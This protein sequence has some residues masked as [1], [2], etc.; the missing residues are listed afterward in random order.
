MAT[1]AIDS[2]S[3]LQFIKGIGPARSKVLAESGLKTVLDLLYYFPRR[4]LN[5]TTVTSIKELKR[6]TNVTVIGSVEVCGERKTRKGKLYQAVL[7]DGTGLINLLWFNGISYVKRSLKIGDRLAVH[8]KIDF[9]KGYQIIHPEYDKLDAVDDPVATGSI[10]PLYPLS[11]D[12]KKVGLD[13]RRL[14]KTIRDVHNQTEKIQ[15]FLP[16]EL[17]KKYQLTDLDSAL[18][19][20]HFA[21]NEDQL[22]KSVYRLKFEEHLFLQILMALRKKTINGLP[23]RILKSTDQLILKIYKHIPYKLT[24]SQNMVLEEI[25]A[26]LAK[27][28]V[29][30]RLLQGDVGSGKTIIGIIAALIAVNNNVQVAVMAPTEILAK[31]HFNVFN[32]FAERTQI[33]CSLLVGKLKPKERESILSALKDGRIN[34]IVGTHALIQSDVEF[35]DLGFVIVDEQHRFGVVQRGNLLAKGNNPHFL[36]MTATPIPRTLAITF[37]GDMDL[38]IIDE[39]PQ[40][41]IPITT[42]VVEPSRLKNI[43][44]FISEE[45]QRGQQCIIVYPL[46]EES[47]KSDLAAA[48]EAHQ[49]LQA[50]IFPQLHVGIIHGRMKKEEKDEVMG[51]FTRNEIQIL[52]ST[53]VIEVGIDIP[54]ATVMLIEHADRFGLTQLHQLRGRVGRGINKS[55]CILVQRNVN[56]TSKARLDI[57]E[58]ISDG[59]EISDEDLKIRGPGEY[60]GIRQSGFLSYRIA[61]LVTDGPIIRSARTAAFDLIKSDP[62]LRRP[63]H[64]DIRSRFIQCYQ[65][66][67]EFVNIN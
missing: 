37:H 21:D 25:L 5:R 26:D 32:K 65:D 39:M 56:E 46:V 57:I 20:I 50:E 63:L 3:A 4:H 60:F 15:D 24:N 44:K 33:T 7:N 36:A 47:E 62:H 16:E 14:R 58:R 27:P 55:F 2:D 52:V 22:A 12:F 49:L 13:N 23:A 30:N 10:I 11:Q 6:G 34:I 19:W 9:Y 17:K 67:L 40:D 18:R 29:M 1:D 28:V 31:Q 51:A 59:F 42:K 64:L 38:S 35:K 45:V 8:G 41:R 54:N 61:N 48:V 66:K 53:S 43:Y